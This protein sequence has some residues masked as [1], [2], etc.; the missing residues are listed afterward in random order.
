MATAGKEQTAL[1]FS[2]GEGE[3]FAFA[4]LWENWESPEKENIVS[5]SIITTAANET[6]QPMHDRMPVILP[7]A[8]GNSGSILLLKMLRKFCPC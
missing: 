7:T 6:V 1:L 5:C 3:P 8:I 4:G 2:N